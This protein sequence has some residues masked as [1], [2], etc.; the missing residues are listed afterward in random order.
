MGSGG[1]H[2]TQNCN[3]LITSELKKCPN[4]HFDSAGWIIN[5][6]HAEIIARRGFLR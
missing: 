5:D 4:F 1:T 6:S 3:Q 2:K